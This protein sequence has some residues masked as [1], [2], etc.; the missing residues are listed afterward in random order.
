MTTTQDRLPMILDEV[1]V[2]R[3]ERLSPSFVRVELGGAC[4]AEF[5]VDGPL[6]DQRI[7]LVFPGVPGG[8]V[9]SFEGVNDSWWETWLSRPEEE[10]GHMR[11]YTVRDVVGEGG[12][13]R[14]V[15][16]IVV[17][18]DAHGDV[19][20]G[21]DWALRAAVGDR[22]VV[23][24]PRRGEQYGGIEFVPGAAA[25][26]LL[27]GDETAVPAICAILA[28][29]P[30]DATGAAYLEVPTAA[31]IQTVQHPEGVAV[32]WLAREGAAHGAGLHAAVLEHL[33]AGGAVTLE[34][35]EEVDPDLWETPTYSSSGED[36]EAAQLVVG[37][38]LGD[39]YAWIAGESGLVTGLRRALVKD[40]GMD[41]R[42]VA[43]MGYW[44]RG[45]AMRS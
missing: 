30:V 24:G 27:V 14:L 18:E 12:D 26:L 10:R 4:L 3:V 6:Y 17:H 11:T 33:G 16:D 25:R 19:G 28:Q 45:V 29:L 8:P 1:E 23:L 22:V 7:K 35:P 9:P 5:G 34:E 32:T 36:V 13:T 44:R 2:V 37:H 39:L 21:C 41:R 40:L 15:V 43:F 38:D 31:D 42:Q 20:P